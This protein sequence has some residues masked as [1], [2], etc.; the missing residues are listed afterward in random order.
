MDLDGSRFHSGNTNESSA[1][2]LLAVGGSDLKE[3][4]GALRVACLLVGSVAEA[5]VLLH[6]GV[7][8]RGW[9]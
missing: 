2:T 3:L 4:N 7:R 9:G 5:E 8:V 1:H 6:V